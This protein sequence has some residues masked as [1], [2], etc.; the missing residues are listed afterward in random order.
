[1]NIFKNIEIDEFGE[2]QMPYASKGDDGW[3]SGYIHI[4]YL[5]KHFRHLKTA[6]KM[7][8]ATKS[9]GLKLYFDW[10]KQKEIID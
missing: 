7:K 6:K 10:L 5:N 8:N 4:D 9:E 1:M 2:T 3:G